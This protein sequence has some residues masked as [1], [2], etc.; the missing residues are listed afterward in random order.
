MNSHTLLHRQVNP[1]FIRHDK[2]SSQAFMPTSQV[3]CPTPKDH[4]M[5]S[6]SDG[7]QITAEH[8]YR[9]FVDIPLGKSIGVLS[10]LVAECTS[11]EVPVVSDPTPEQPDHCFIDFRDKSNSQAAKI[12]TKLRNHAICRGWSHRAMQ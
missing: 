9:R 11:L 3:F 10:V 1:T 8:A 12:A 5:L 6:V 4:G 2:T 7:D